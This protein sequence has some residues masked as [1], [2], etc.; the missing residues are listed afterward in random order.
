MLEL[1]KDKIALLDADYLIYHAIHPEKVLDESGEPMK[2]N[3]K[4]VYKPWEDASQCIEKLNTILFSIYEEFQD[5]QFIGFLSLTKTFRNE[6]DETY[7]ANRTSEK[8]PFFYEVREYMSK[9]LGFIHINGLEADDL[10]NIFYNFFEKEHVTVIRMSPDKDILNL[11]GTNYNPVKKEWFTR[12]REEAKLYFWT[13]M[14]VGDT[15][16][17]IKGIPKKGIK[18]AETLLNEEDPAR[19]PELVFAEYVKHF[20]ECQGL[21]EFYKNFKKLKILSESDKIKLNLIEDGGLEIR[22]DEQS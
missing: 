18:F 9:D 21:S 1:N 17:N 7:K 14:I 15:A 10:V 22:T 19:Y 5:F 16:D 6:I 13:S 20:G 4:L 11:E 8:P 2:E 12:T 3:G